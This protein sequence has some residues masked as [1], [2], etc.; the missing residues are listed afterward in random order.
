MFLNV[1]HGR[2]SYELNVEVGSIADPL[3]RSYRLP[4]VL[5]T[6]LGRDDKRQ[7]YF[8]ASN[9]EAVCRC[10]QR[11]AD[12]VSQHYGSVLRGDAELLERI[13]TQRSEKS[14]A[15]EREMVQRP[16][17]EAAERAWHAKDYAKVQELYASIRADLT[18]IERKRLEYAEK[19]GRGRR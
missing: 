18:L 9:R 7:T 2:Q 19:H 5:D 15:E 16:V 4:D 6:V 17:R 3:S 1:Y 8:Q 14:R 12:L 10:V 11:I 13:D